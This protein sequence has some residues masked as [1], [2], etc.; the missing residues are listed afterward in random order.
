MKKTSYILLMIACMLP[1]FA[2]AQTKR[3]KETFNSDD[4]IRFEWEEY[5]DKK[6]G[7]EIK[8]DCL[9]ITNKDKN[10][11]RM[12]FVNIPI[13]VKN[14]FKISTSIIVPNLNDKEWFAITFDNT[15]DHHKM[16]FYIKE[17]FFRFKEIKIDYT[18][19]DLEEYDPTM[20]RI[21]TIWQDR[22]IPIKLK[23]GKNITVNFVIEKKGENLIL[24]INN[25]KVDELPVGDDLKSANLGFIV[26]GNYSIK[27]DEILV[28]Q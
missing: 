28:E 18:D 5:V 10:T 20:A 19:D 8:D 13:N 7:V 23:G 26:N 6:G 2:N 1:M 12:V 25:M 27:I 17:N 16:A 4:K 9:V 14:S 21:T 15:K 24:S 3:I 11:S 22:R